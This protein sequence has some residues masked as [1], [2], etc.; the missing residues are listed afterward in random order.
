MEEVTLEVYSAAT[1][2]AIVRMP[3]R[4]QCGRRRAG[5]RRKPQDRK[6]VEAMGPEPGNRWTSTHPENRWWTT[7][8]G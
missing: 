3:G 4:P 2:S 8:L 1:N 5:T 7:A 6:P